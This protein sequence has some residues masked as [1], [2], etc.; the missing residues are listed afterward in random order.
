MPIGLTEID[1]Q[2]S[3][4]NE[5]VP[6]RSDE[7]GSQ[8]TLCGKGIEGRGQRRGSLHEP[9]VGSSGAVIA[10]RADEAQS[11]ERQSL[12]RK[13]EVFIW[14]RHESELEWASL[15]IKLHF[16]EQLI[17]RGIDRLVVCVE[18]AI[19]LQP[20]SNGITDGGML[21]ETTP[22][23]GA[24]QGRHSETRLTKCSGDQNKI[25]PGLVRIDLDHNTKG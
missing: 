23:P 12:L 17:Q 22:T 3:L 19:C 20:C 21:G 25:Y 14:E 5:V 6:C 7:H 10:A 15:H 11:D 16:A 4:V 13:K 9:V 24:L 2:I 8:I 18:H 1:L